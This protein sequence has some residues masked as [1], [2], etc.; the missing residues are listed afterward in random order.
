MIYFIKELRDIRIQYPVHLLA[1]QRDRQRIQQVV[2]A[3]SHRNHTT[4]ECPNPKMF[5]QYDLYNSGNLKLLAYS[6]A[7][8]KEKDFYLLFK[9]MHL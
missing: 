5:G 7:P 3:T 6:V 2:M 9:L 8:L 4:P 1:L